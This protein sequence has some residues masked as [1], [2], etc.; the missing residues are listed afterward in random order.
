MEY[1]LII[2]LQLSGIG[3]HVMQKII[4]IGNLH[5][6]KPASETFKIFMRED[7]D[8]LCVSAIVLFLNIIVHYIVGEYAQSIS[9]MEYYTLT[10]FAI[11]LVLG[12]A[13]Q[14]MIYKYLGS[15]EKFL[16]KQVENRLK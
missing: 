3:L 12:Y 5:P 13:G 4:G 15:A 9:A 11:A 6:D 16:D 1:L 8:T 14:R 10:S 2:S 7:W